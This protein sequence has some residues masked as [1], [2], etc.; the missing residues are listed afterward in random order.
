MMP[1][2]VK[3]DN[4][5]GTVLAA[6]VNSTLNPPPHGNALASSPPLPPQARPGKRQ[7]IITSD[8]ESH[9]LP[10]LH[11]QSMNAG[12]SLE[13]IRAEPNKKMRHLETVFPEVNKELGKEG[14]NYRHSREAAL[15]AASKQSTE[16]L[17]KSDSKTEDVK[18][19]FQ[20]AN[21]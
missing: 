3:K 15:A 20:E 7:W 13:A 19:L 10:I 5:P 21:N 8:D 18:L 17:T 9:S 14:H 12:H 11:A 1:D 16:A 6:A 4:V 2:D